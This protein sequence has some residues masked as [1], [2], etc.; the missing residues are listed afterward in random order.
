MEYRV[1]N[2]PS[3]WTVTK[4]LALNLNKVTRLIFLILIKSTSS[5]YPRVLLMTVNVLNGAVTTKF[6]HIFV[7]LTFDQQGKC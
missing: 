1:S 6:L 7:T 4:M 3:W 2:E 5:Y